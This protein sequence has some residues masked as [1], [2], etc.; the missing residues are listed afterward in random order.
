M[1]SI[2]ETIMNLKI[3]DLIYR[4][5]K[6]MPEKV[7]QY[8]ID[9]FKNNIEKTGKEASKKLIEGEPISYQLDNFKCLHLNN[10]SE[11]N[12]EIEQAKNLAFKYIEMM[13]LNYTQFLKINI[14]SAINSEWFTT[15]SNI[16]IIRYKEG[17]Q[18]LDHLDVNR[19]NR[20]ACTINLNEDYE[21]GEFS[22]F[23]GKEL[24]TFKTGDSIIFPAEPIFIHGTKKIKKG[25]RYSINCFLYN[26]DQANDIK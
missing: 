13:I 22:F 11:K 2:T 21:G 20:A 14:S 17:E 9:F 16:R 15:T 1:V 6:I 7:C 3:K 25:T 5:D 4:K 19:R 26:I 8:F 10:L 24:Y 23:S 18:I 12:P